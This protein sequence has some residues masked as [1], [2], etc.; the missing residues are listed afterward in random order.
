[1]KKKL[2]NNGDCTDQTDVNSSIQLVSY[3]RVDNEIDLPC[4]RNVDNEYSTSK[5]S[6]A[7][8]LQSDTGSATTVQSKLSLIKAELASRGST[9]AINRVKN[10]HSITEQSQQSGDNPGETMN[11]KRRTLIKQ[12]T[13]EVLLGNNQSGRNDEAN[14]N[15]DVKESCRSLN[16]LTCTER[17]FQSELYKKQSNVRFVMI[18]D[19]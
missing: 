11:N 3:K 19:Y 7:S 12:Q 16:N 10:L 5:G 6:S 2:A 15:N 18:K 14:L 9:S 13:H 1:M 17:E 4:V 8:S